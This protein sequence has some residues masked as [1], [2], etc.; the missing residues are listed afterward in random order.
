[1]PECIAELID[2]SVLAGERWIVR[3]VSFGVPSRGVTALLGPN[4]CGKSTLSRVLLG[5]VWPTRGTVKLLGHTLGQVDVQSLR[6]RAQL[7]QAQPVHQP[8][9]GMTARDVVHTGPFGTIDLYDVP[10]DAQRKRADE[11]LNQ[12]GVGSLA[13][14]AYRTMS[15]GERMR[16][17]IARALLAE[18]KLLILDEPTAGLD[19]GRAGGTGR[20]DRPHEHRPRRAGR[21]ADHAPC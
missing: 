19:S 2:V 16:T 7:V 1:M 11:L 14:A 4:G 5:Q 17:L 8:S 13:D 3:S 20:H 10:T 15:T 21:T 6:R 9:E 12:L 18:P